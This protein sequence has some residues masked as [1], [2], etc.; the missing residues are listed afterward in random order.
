MNT[1]AAASEYLTDYR[2]TLYSITHPSGG[3]AITGIG[4]RPLRASAGKHT[5]SRAFRT[6]LIRDVEALLQSCSN[7]S[8]S[9]RKNRD[10]STADKLFGEHA[11][12]LTHEVSGRTF[13]FWLN[14]K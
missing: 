6:G 14:L 5:V 13:F 8:A 4:C 12:Q 1:V 10:R 9:A 2:G 7:K 3:K 11:L